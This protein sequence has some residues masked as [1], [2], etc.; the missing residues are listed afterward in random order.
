VLQSDNPFTWT[1]GEISERLDRGLVS[2]SWLD[3]FPNAELF[4]LPPTSSDHSPL[5]VKLDSRIKMGAHK[6]VFRF[7]DM[8]TSEEGCEYVIS[9]SWNDCPSDGSMQGL[10]EK[11]LKCSE[12][13]LVWN[14]DHFGNVQRHL[15]LC[16]DRFKELRVVVRTLDII[17]EEDLL[18][19]DFE[20]ALGRE[21][22][23]WRQKPV[24][25]G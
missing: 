2:Q 21:E 6:R 1:H 23:L 4:V 22:Q 16:Q 3:L 9:R 8:W 19:T 7:E 5:L 15:R 25:F 18:I 12:D 13:L 11:I 10:M 24:N 14:R 17:E 20:R